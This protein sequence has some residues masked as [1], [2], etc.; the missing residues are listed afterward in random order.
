MTRLQHEKG[1]P[2]K[3]IIFLSPSA[4]DRYTKITLK[5]KDNWNI[6][7][8]EH[9][10]YLNVKGTLWGMIENAGGDFSRQY[11]Y[12]ESEKTHG[13]A[14]TGYHSY[15][16]FASPNEAKQYLERYFEV[17]GNA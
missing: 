11:G 9:D 16:K 15:A 2:M 1:Q 5:E 14:G 6:G 12:Q 3:N 10:G 7:C 4:G 13:V 17:H 8:I